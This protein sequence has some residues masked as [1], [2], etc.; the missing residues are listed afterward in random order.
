MCGI[1]GYV[2]N[3]DEA[4]L[5]KMTKKISHRGPDGE[6]A[7]VCKE[8]GLGHRR[9]SIIDL[10]E[11]ASQPMA[12]DD[13]RY[14]VTFNGEIYNYKELAHDLQSKGY[15]FNENSD[16][17]IL[18]P[19]YDAYGEGMLKKLDGIFAFA[20]WDTKDKSLFAA[21]DHLGMKPFYYAETAKG[22]A[23]AS[24]LKALLEVPSVP[25][26]L[27]EDSILAY[28]RYLW[29][30]GEGT[31][32]K[33]VKKL[34]PG[35]F[36]T[37]SED[38]FCLISQWYKPPLHQEHEAR[39]PEELLSIF[40]EVVESQIMS[41]VPVGAFLSGGVD[42]SA[43]VASMKKSTGKSFDT[44]CLGFKGDAMAS[45]G[46]GSDKYYAQKVA[47]QVGVKLH[48]VTAN[49]GFVSELADMVYHL[50]EPQA[51][52]APIYI[53]HI[54]KAAKRKKIKVL[55]S[56]AGG[57]DVFSGYRR[58]QVTAMLDKYNFIPQPLQRAG[59]SALAVVVPS[60][61]LKRRLKKLQ[62][63]VK[64]P[65]DKRMLHAFYYTSPSVL[66]PL[67]SPRMKKVHDNKTADY[68]E[69]ILDKSEGYD[70]VNRQLDLELHG[71][72]PDHNLNYTDKM[73]MA[74]GVE[75]R[76]PFTSKKIVDFAASLP[77]DQKIRGGE[78]KWMLKKAMENRLSH[79]VLYRS[80]AGFGAP[81]RTWLLKED[82]FL[83]DILFSDKA[84]DRD[85]FNYNGIQN[86]IAQ[87]RLGVVDGSY[88]ILSLLVIE[89]WLLQF[90]DK[91][92]AKK[93][94]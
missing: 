90:F 93:L 42:S 26:D 92:K 44:F 78:A 30:A 2:G 50:D 21:R 19:L 80:K 11:G 70:N 84:R 79:D 33:A 15:H 82:K 47:D 61:N 69:K 10:S 51:D 89:L 75:V 25:R 91:K 22:M 39:K 54:C 73:S 66:Y 94:K 62:D 20:I 35:H 5:K 52:P 38:C 87:T 58:H 49:E 46:F 56:G 68:L 32:L 3:F 31:M 18:A 9:L 81:V 41:D 14:M 67:L 64:A 17:A 57:D 86:L 74:S 28:V 29:C 77:I 40:D 88:T 36:M 37:V 43:I 76:T 7:W 60:S 59:L 12:S 23:F 6:G 63:I 65:T 13:G 16:T 8:A 53:K 55:L 83:K 1:A 72:L 71:F 27:D 45:E 4:V 34:L 24:E 85:L 48:H